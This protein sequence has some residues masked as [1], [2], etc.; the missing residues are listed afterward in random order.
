[1]KITFSPWSLLFSFALF[2]GVL[3]EA[4]LGSASRE[5]PTNYQ[6]EL[7]VAVTI[8]V[9][10][11][12]GAF[13]SAVEETPPEGWLVSEISNGGSFDAVNNKVKWVFLD[14]ETR[15]L[16]YQATPPS[17]ETGIQEFSGV[18]SFDGMNAPIGGSSSISSQISGENTPG[19]T[20]SLPGSYQPGSPVTVTIVVL[21]GTGAFSSAVEETPPEGWLVAEISD[22]GN[23][24]AVNNKVKWV[25][26]DGET[27]TL[28]YQATPPPGE[29]GVK[30]FSG[31]AS[32]DGTDV[33][34]AGA[35]EIQ[36]SGGNPTRIINLLGEL[37]FGSVAPGVSVNLAMTIRNDG[38]SPL[39]VTGLQHSNDAFTGN[40]TGTIAAGSL[41]IVDIT[42]APPSSGLFNNTITV[43]SNATAGTGTIN[44]SG[45]GQAQ[46]PPPSN[47][48]EMTIGQLIASLTLPDVVLA[49]GAQV[50]SIRGL[51][52]GIR[53]DRRSG[54]L[55]GRA[56][57]AGEFNAIAVVINDQNQ[58]ESRPFTVQV[59][60]LPEYVEGL[61]EAVFD[62]SQESGEM[63]IER[64]GRVQVAINSGGILTGALQL[65][66][67]RFPIRQQVEIPFAELDQPLSVS[68]VLR[69]NPRDPAQDI[70]LEL[71]FDES[72]FGATLSQANIAPVNSLVGRQIPWS[73]FNRAVG[74][75]AVRH[76]I[77]LFSQGN[78]SQ[79]VFTLNLVTR[80]TG[81]VAWN[82]RNLPGSQGNYRVSGTALLGPAGELDLYA[83]LRKMEGAFLGSLELEPSTGSISSPVN[84]KLNIWPTFF[85]PEGLQILMSSE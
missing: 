83:P 51:P 4:S 37:Q 58:R 60:A 41:Q 9:I 30:Q 11:P 24:D 40:F 72:S 56:R 19:A 65:G 13:S 69:P 3:L 25:F 79:P 16:T 85:L 55:V 14:G 35:H 34:V 78:S 71:Q 57:I 8:S 23:F 64:G 27:R 59:A 68:F 74:G 10:P 33:P 61:F 62:F 43:L 67:R 75:K 81:Q 6:P 48:A 84:S 5:L 18:A 54:T 73:R 31:L 45:V 63:W 77:N 38:D 46:E 20:R 82:A 36:L 15:T 1:M 76:V 80:P 42:F 21:P 66:S 17:G 2:F 28:T 52:R 26:L 49:G 7:P 39:Q 47:A 44:A 29:T 12:A 32:F 53:F 70:Q 50:L 22:G